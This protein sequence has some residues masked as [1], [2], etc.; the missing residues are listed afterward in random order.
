MKTTLAV[1]VAV[2]VLG[3]Q[4]VQ[5]QTNQDT[6]QNTGKKFSVQ[7]W[8]SDQKLALLLIKDRLASKSETRS[9]PTVQPVPAVSTTN[10][11]PKIVVTGEVGAPVKPPFK[12]SFV[13][14]GPIKIEWFP[15]YDYSSPTNGGLTKGLRP[16]AGVVLKFTF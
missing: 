9:A 11:I 3:G 2:A 12:Q 10:A 5:A 14:E 1:A 8:E 15:K 16:P 6:G 7:K 4:S 13:W